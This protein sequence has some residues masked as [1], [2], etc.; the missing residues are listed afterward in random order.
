MNSVCAYCQNKGAFIYELSNQCCTVF[1][2][3]DC[4]TNEN[5]LTLKGCHVPLTVF[6]LLVKAV[7]IMHI[8]RASILQ[9]YNI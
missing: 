2:L 4:M 1:N 5:N 3:L 6:F 9:I 7:L 8:W